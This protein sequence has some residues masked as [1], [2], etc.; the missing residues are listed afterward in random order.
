VVSAVEFWSGPMDGGFFQPIYRSLLLFF[1]R[2]LDF[3]SDTSEKRGTW[4]RLRRWCYVGLQVGIVVFERTFNPS[5]VGSLVRSFI[6]SRKQARFEPS[7][8]SSPVLLLKLNTGSQTPSNGTDHSPV[9]PSF[10]H[11]P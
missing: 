11:I 6:H 2:P 4:T 9:C 1:R 10:Y 5:L 7:K 3:L 8:I